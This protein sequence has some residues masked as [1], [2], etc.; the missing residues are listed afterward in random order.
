[1]M[2]VPALREAVMRE[3]AK[4]VPGLVPAPLPAEP[5]LGAVHLACDLV[6]SK[7]HLPQSE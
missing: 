5:A 3:L 1:M 6:A 2:G 7:L 4:C